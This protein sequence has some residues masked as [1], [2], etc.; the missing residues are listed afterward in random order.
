MSKRWM[1]LPVLALL[2]LTQACTGFRKPTIELEGVQL[3]SV[4]LTGG[5]LLVNVR[6]ENPNAIGFRVEN[7]AYELFLRES[8]DSADEQGWERLTSG[9]YDEDIAIRARETR[10][11]QLPIEFRFADLGPVAQSVMRTGRF[12]YRVAGTVQVR[13]AGTTRTVPFRKTGS[14]SLLGR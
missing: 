8:G 2:V 4:G 6:V 12:N 14:M 5:T 1:M 10:T 11:V 3:G 7:V 9:N 13:A